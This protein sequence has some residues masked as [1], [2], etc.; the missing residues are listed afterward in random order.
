MVD[1]IGPIDV[2]NA[3]VRWT[4]RLA[5]AGLAAFWLMAVAGRPGPAARRTVY[6]VA[7]ALYILHVFAAFQFVHDWNHAA[8]W[9]EVARQTEAATG[10]A[11]G[12][13][14]LVNH[15]VTLLWT[16]DVV[17]RWTAR[18]EPPPARV[19]IVRV[20]VQAVLIFVTVQATVVFGPPGWW[21]VA[22]AYCIG[23]G[24]IWAVGRGWPNL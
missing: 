8:A 17:L 6:T 15:A 11:S 3:L 1:L 9:A 14:L 2:G 18:C 24:T 19:R 7:W 12:V 16:A 22:T 4:V 5:V 21:I 23:L 20:V 10:V 13:G